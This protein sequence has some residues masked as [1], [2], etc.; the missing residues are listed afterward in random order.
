MPDRVGCTGF[1]ENILTLVGGMVK[2]RTLSTAIVP[3]CRERSQIQ[4][5]EIRQLPNNEHLFEST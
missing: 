2:V 3:S 4:Q 5:Y 1:T